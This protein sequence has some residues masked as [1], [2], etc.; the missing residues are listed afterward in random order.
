MV[1]WVVIFGM[2]VALSAYAVSIGDGLEGL[3][4]F[5]EGSGDIARDSSGNGRDGEIL[6][7]PAW[8][9]GVFGMALEFDGVDDHVVIS[10]YT[11]V[12]GNTPRTVMLWWK[13]YDARE[14]SWVKWGIVQDTRKYYVRAHLAGNTCFLRVETQGG[15]HY[16]STDVCNGEWHH[17]AV[18][19]PPDS[20]NVKDH[21]LYVDGVLE[22]QTA[23]NPVGVDTDVASQEV[24][25][26]APLA[27]H[28]YAHGVMDE[29][30]I[31]SRAL[32]KEEI[33]TIMNNGFRLSLAVS[34]AGK[35][36]T[37]WAAL[38]QQ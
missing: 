9:D 33:Q 2:T 5:D 22:E 25:I 10:G 20:D 26:G 34:P 3:W 36:A 35:L 32:S 28:V 11:G 6:G 30:A 13:A 16:G 7:N 27:H 23:G 17:L 14:H 19:F 29:V 12:G 38:K 37:R 15:Q 21:L 31:Y 24:N 18:V 1:R 4:L 8:V